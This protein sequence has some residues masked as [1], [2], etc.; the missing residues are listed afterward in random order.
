VSRANVQTKETLSKS[1]SMRFPVLLS[2]SGFLKFSKILNFNSRFGKHSSSL[3]LFISKVFFSL[4]E[5]HFCFHDSYNFCSW[6]ASAISLHAQVQFHAEYRL[7]DSQSERS[8]NFSYAILIKIRFV[9]LFCACIKMHHTVHLYYLIVNFSVTCDI[10]LPW[11]HN[12]LNEVVIII[13][14]IYY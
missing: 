13:N 1:M 2:V 9:M 7:F 10:L 6:L 4:D 5:L 14:L 8:F 11:D 3:N 12:V